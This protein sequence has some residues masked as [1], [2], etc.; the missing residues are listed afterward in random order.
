MPQSSRLPPPR[1]RKGRPRLCAWFLLPNTP[2]P[3]AAVP[4]PRQYDGPQGESGGFEK[5]KNST[6][7]AE[8]ARYVPCLSGGDTLASWP[9]RVCTVRAGRG[10]D[11]LQG[12]VT[13]AAEALRK[14]V[15]QGRVAVLGTLPD[16]CQ[17]TNEEACCTQR[18]AAVPQNG[19]GASVHSGRR[20]GHADS[21]GGG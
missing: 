6:D 18:I 3:P 17:T 13:E 14:K 10:L 9:D 5:G 15:R 1:R 8:P 11:D 2:P 12:V 4:F 16:A 7:T 19:D 20:R 21:C